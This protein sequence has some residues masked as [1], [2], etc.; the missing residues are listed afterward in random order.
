MASPTTPQPNTPPTTTTITTVE[1]P[2]REPFV[3]SYL[4]PDARDRLLRYEYHGVDNSYVYR[5]FW[6]PLCRRVVEWLP[7]WL[8]P[9]VITV[10]A[11]LIVTVPH[12]L[13][14]YYMPKLTVMGTDYLY[15]SEIKGTTL[16]YAKEF[17]P[18]PPRYIFI[19]GALA[20]F[21]YQF[22]DNLDG[23]QARRTGTSSPLGLLMDHGC[24]AVNCII[25]GLSL[26]CVVSDGPCWKTWVMVLD[27]L[28]V[29]FLNTWE[30]Y[31]RGVLVLPVVNGP[32]EGI[33]IAIGTYLWTAWVGG[34]HWWYTNAL[35]IPSAWLPHILRQP[36]PEA[37]VAVESAVLRRVCPLLTKLT[38]LDANGF[39]ALPFFFNFNCTAERIAHPPF[40]TR[41]AFDDATRDARLE[42]LVVGKL[43]SGDGVIQSAVLRLYG[44][45]EA[46]LRVRYNTILVVV[47]T[48][49]AV[50]T[51]LGNV[52][53]VYRAIR[54]TPQSEWEA[55]RPPGSFQRRFPFLHALTRL[56]PL[57][58]LTL[59]ANIWFLTSQENVFRRHPRIFCWTVGLLYT[60]LVIHLML[61]HLCGI[62]FRP[63]RRTFVPFLLFGVHITLTYVH[64]VNQLLRRQR[65]LGVMDSHGNDTEPGSRIPNADT[66]AAYAYDLDEELILYEFFALSIITFIH[67]AVN[68]VGE[69]ARA[70]EVPVFTVPKGKQ[71]ALRRRIAAEKPAQN[72]TKGTP[73][74]PSKAKAAKPSVSSPVVAAP[75]SAKKEK[76]GQ[77]SMSVSASAAEP[78]AS[79][80]S[81]RGSPN[82]K[83]EPKNATSPMSSPTSRNGGA[84]A[85]A[86][87][88]HSATSGKQSH[89]PSNRKG[90]S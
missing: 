12:V 60:K 58:V 88:A 47:M 5:F 15:R 78:S 30:E 76:A 42:Q 33:F 36:A 73:V 56:A 44:V 81:P 79:K 63:F 69:T 29:F 43:W 40:P 68:V 55:R 14:A 4:P 32:N 39:A 3:G 6:R 84:G 90:A 34:P 57:V 20:L 49:L 38:P 17:L 1:E 48:A 80:G 83:T 66:Y 61:A 62:T 2:H 77:P 31:Y 45:S 26:C 75:S 46:T 74:A 51:C 21:L 64:N 67:L 82:A 22:L 23:H 87:A 53:Q 65:R 13:L 41:V 50:A 59:M 27:T 11:L 28:I 72:G 54:R 70:L 37:A 24:D 52:Y 35:E 8:A 85:C 71:A 19:L 9:N 10:A 25:G 18:P 16:P 86:K 7:V 89:Q